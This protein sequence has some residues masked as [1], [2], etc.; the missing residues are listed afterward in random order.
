[1]QKPIGESQQDVL[2]ESSS[3]SCEQLFQ[4]I[5]YAS[6]REARVIPLWQESYH[7]GVCK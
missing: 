3:Q 5:L 7:E 6:H 2:L 4:R 1:M